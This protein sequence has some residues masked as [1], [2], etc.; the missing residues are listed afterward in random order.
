MEK[1]LT[2]KEVAA[3]TRT[4]LGWWRQRITRKEI[5]FYR[6]GKR[7]LIPESTLDQILKGGAVDPVK[8]AA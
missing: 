5:R 3:I 7:T 4:S 1:L 6:L 2:V 8:P